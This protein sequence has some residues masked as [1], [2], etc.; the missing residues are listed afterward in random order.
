MIARTIS[1]I[2]HPAIT[3]PITSIAILLVTAS[4]SSMYYWLG[5]A[6]LLVIGLVFWSWT[7]VRDGKWRHI[8]ASASTERA[9]WNRASF[10]CL[11][12]GAIFAAIYEQW[13]LS[14]GLAASAF[15]LG[16][17]IATSSYVRLSQ[18]VAFATLATVIASI[19]SLNFALLMVG[20]TCAIAWSRLELERHKL[21]DLAAG[22]AVGG[23]AGYGIVLTVVQVI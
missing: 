8:D 7:N 16:T 1:T 21:S 9:E 11:L 12:S 6:C 23:V 20:V 5:A 2:G 13:I 18:H 4:P 14:S 10:L 17:A 3:V 22:L 19:A 15:I